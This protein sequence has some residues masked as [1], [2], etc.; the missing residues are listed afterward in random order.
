MVTLEDIVEKAYSDDLYKQRVAYDELGPHFFDQ[1]AVEIGKR[2]E[3][4]GEAVPVVTGMFK[5]KYT[6]YPAADYQRIL[7]HDAYLHVAKC[8]SRVFR[9]LRRDVRREHICR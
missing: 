4:C 5:V 3:A 2:L 7:W 9:P 8:R 1:L 6:S